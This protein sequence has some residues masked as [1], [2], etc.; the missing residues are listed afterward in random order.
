MGVDHGGPDVL[1]AQQFLNGAEV[2]VLLQ[3]V[4]V[5]DLASL[6]LPGGIDAALIEQAMST[7][8]EPLPGMADQQRRPHGGSLSNGDL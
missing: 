1:V 8:P 2:L 5:G 4:G 3:Q 7:G 6:Q